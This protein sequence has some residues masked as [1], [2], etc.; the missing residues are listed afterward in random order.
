VAPSVGI[1]VFVA[2]GVLFATGRWRSEASWLDRSG[3][4]LGVY[5]ILLA[6]VIGVMAQLWKF[7][8]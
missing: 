2:W 7:L 8:I 4:F 5:W 1:A 6:I 3:R